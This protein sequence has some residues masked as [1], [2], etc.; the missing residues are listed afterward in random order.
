ML[1]ERRDDWERKHDERAERFEDRVSARIT[2]VHERLD[3][4]INLLI[5]SKISKAEEAKL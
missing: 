2:R 1:K 5:E 3:Q 4:I